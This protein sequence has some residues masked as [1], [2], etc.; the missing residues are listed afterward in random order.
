LGEALLLYGYEV[1]LNDDLRVDL[2]WSARG[3]VAE[4]YTVFVH[5]V[6]AD[7]RMVDQRDAMPRDNTYPTSL[8]VAGEYV[9]DT[10]RFEIPAPG[11]Y[12]L[13]AGLYRQADGARLAVTTLTGDSLGDYREIGPI[14]IEW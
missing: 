14:I 11:E 9:P 5:L 2:V 1:E 10:Y 13:R 3:S 7:G 6:D 4:D 12:W 8:W